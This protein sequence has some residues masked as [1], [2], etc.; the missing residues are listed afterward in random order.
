MSEEAKT[1]DP[2]SRRLEV[3]EEA[4][5]DQEAEETPQ[6]L[7]ADGQQQLV[8]QKMDELR[9]AGVNMDAL[10]KAMSPDGLPPTGSP[11]VSPMGMPIGPG[12]QH[13]MTQIGAPPMVA[14]PPPPMPHMPDPTLMPEEAPLHQQQRHPGIKHVKPAGPDVRMMDDGLIQ[15][16]P[17][18]MMEIELLTAEQRAAT[19]EEKLATRA[20]RDARERL[21]S[22]HRKQSIL[23]SN[24]TSKLG[25]PPGGSIR[26]VDKEQRLCR[27]EE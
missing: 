15:L 6:K 19:A 12:M 22:L 11:M 13:P 17:M 16:D 1:V 9:E 3:V 14:A 25:L 21:M 10:K 27:I 4:L 24:I 18:M 2:E 26:L 5:G 23:M 20:L 8:Q 7:D